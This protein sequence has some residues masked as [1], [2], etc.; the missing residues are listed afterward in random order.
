MTDN[1]KPPEGAPTPPVVVPPKTFSADEVERMIAQATAKSTN[2]LLAKLGAKSPDE[3]SQALGKYRETEEAQKSELQRL[4]EFKAKAE[5]ELAGAKAYRD[6]FSAMLAKQIDGL[7]PERK[8]ALSA[9]AGDDPLKL[10]TA[11]EVLGPTWAAPIVPP[12]EAPK[13]DAPVP[14]A[15]Q[16]A[17]PAAPPAPAPKPPAAPANAALPGGAP[18]P[19][20]APKTKWEEFEA[21]KSPIAKNVF[22]SVHSKAIEESRPNP[23]AN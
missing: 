8:A 5:Q 12:T 21:I 16:Q 10:A 9:L 4:V 7:T 3:I 22:Y 17:A 13:V 18:I 2:D 14:P 15:A 11:L 6:R 19:S 20:T 1:P 23:P